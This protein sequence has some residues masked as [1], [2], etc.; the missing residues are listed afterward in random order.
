MSLMKASS[1]DMCM[2]LS[3]AADARCTANKTHADDSSS[4]DCT[5]LMNGII[6]DYLRFAAGVCK[7]ARTFFKMC[8]FLLWKKSGGWE[9]VGLRD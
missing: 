7:D 2:L 6:D 3:M 8:F 9:V 5:N 4:V 1:S